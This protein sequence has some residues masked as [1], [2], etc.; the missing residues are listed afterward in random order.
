VTEASATNRDGTELS[1]LWSSGSVFAV[2]KPAGIS[3]QSP[4]GF[5]SLEVRLRA[6]FGRQAEYLAFPHRLDRAVS[7]VILVATTKGSAKLLG[8]QFESRKVA[9]T[10]LACVSGNAA[11]VEREWIDAT[12]KLS[13]EAKV[14]IV[15]TG[16]EGAKVCETNVELRGYNAQRGCTVLRL[17][18][19]T[20]RMHQLRVQSARRGHPILGDE[21]YGWPANSASPFH[22]LRIALHAE[23]ITFHEPKTGR[24]VTVCAPLWAEMNEI[25]CSIG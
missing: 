24:I 25:C 1:V 14:E 11:K 13:D 7:G 8:A 12:R 22:P 6:Q 20:G 23:T 2:N 21:L 9:K 10:Y 3:T 15:D 16:A 5:D 18:P 4:G 19:R 17:R